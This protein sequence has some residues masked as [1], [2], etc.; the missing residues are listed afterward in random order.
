[1]GPVGH[2]VQSE[3]THAILE[4]EGDD[5]DLQRESMWAVGI[6]MCGC[7]GCVFASVICELNNKILDI[8]EHKEI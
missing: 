1:V 6:N 8:L 2:G 4:V 3:L 5:L 7:G